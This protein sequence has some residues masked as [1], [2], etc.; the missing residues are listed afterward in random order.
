MIEVRRTEAFTSW[1]DALR[2]ERAKVRITSRIRMLALGNFAE[3]KAVGDH[4]VQELRIDY[5]LGVVARARGMSQHATPACAAKA[6]TRRC[7]SKAT[8]SSP[9]S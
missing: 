9:R 4:S 2:D 7:L 3:H 6:C 8:L 5:G 1:L